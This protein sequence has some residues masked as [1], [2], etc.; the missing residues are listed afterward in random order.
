M[1]KLKAARQYR[2]VT[3]FLKLRTNDYNANFIKHKNS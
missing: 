2:L 1:K 3:E